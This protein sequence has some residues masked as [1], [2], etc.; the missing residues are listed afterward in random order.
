MF[1][2]SLSAAAASNARPEE[3]QLE[4]GEVRLQ[5]LQHVSKPAV[6]GLAGVVSVPMS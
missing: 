3:S 4:P 1:T 5:G 6:K 2:F